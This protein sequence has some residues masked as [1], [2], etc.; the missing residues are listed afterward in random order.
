MAR[1]PYVNDAS[2]PGQSK[3]PGVPGTCCYLVVPSDAADLATPGYVRADAAGA[4]KVRAVGDTSPVTLN[5]L[6]GE[7]TPFLVA[8]VYATPAPPVVHCITYGTE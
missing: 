7:C 8:R 3:Y 6:Q 5:M 1:T 4:V 2:Q